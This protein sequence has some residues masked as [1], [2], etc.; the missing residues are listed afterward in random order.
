MGRDQYRSLAFDNTVSNNSLDE[1]GL[2][3]RDLHTF[4]EYLVTSGEP[5]GANEPGVAD[6]VQG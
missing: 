3:S 5:A 2:N 1:F 6:G 4:G